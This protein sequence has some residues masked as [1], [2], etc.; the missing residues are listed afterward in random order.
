MPSPHFIFY[1]ILKCEMELK[2]NELYTYLYAHGVSGEQNTY[3][4][5]K[6]IITVLLLFFNLKKIHGEKKECITSAYYFTVWI[7]K[8]R[9][10]MKMR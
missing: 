7:L 2:G 9:T 10:W 8:I 4:L 3:K 5:K 6:N 1:L